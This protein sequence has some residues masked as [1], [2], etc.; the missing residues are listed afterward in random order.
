MQLITMS[1]GFPK[2]SEEVRPSV[3]NKALKRLA[4]RASSNKV[5]KKS[6]KPSKNNSVIRSRNKENISKK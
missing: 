5:L 3:W 2:R 6:S 4:N 1:P